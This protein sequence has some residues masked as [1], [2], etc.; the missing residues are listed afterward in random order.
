MKDWLLPNVSDKQTQGVICSSVAYFVHTWNSSN[1]AS[2]KN[3][4]SSIFSLL[5]SSD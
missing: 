3:H 5:S 1:I 2:H 4:S